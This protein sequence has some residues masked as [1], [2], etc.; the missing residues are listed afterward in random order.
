[1]EMYLEQGMVIDSGRVTSRMLNALLH[2]EDKADQ[3]KLRTMTDRVE[4]QGINY[5]TNQEEWADEVLRAHGFDPTTALPLANTV[6]DTAVLSPSG[7]FVDRWG[8]QVAEAEYREHVTEVISYFN[9]NRDV[10]EQIPE[11]LSKVRMM[12]TDPKSVVKVSLDGVFVKR[13]KDT[14]SPQDQITPESAYITDQ[15]DG[16]IDYSR[17][18][19]SKGRPKVETAVGH[20]EVDEKKYVLIGKNMFAVTKMVL[21]FLLEHDLLKNRTLVFFTDGGKDIKKCVDDLFAFCPHYVVLDWFHL[22]KHSLETLSMGLKG[23]KTNR[24]MQYEV[25]RRLFRILWVGNVEGAINYLEH[26]NPDW[27]KNKELVEYLKKKEPS[28]ACYALRRKMGLQI[29]SN[30]VEKANDLVVASRQKSKGMSW[31][32][33]GSWALACV[34][35]MYLNREEDNWHRKNVLKRELYPEYGKVFSVEAA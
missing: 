14:R 28:I 27:V 3:I 20:I 6:I 12:E 5:M 26:L 22:L 19:E 8:N 1:M 11:D 23:G 13:Q 31:S 9:E 29:S 16:P 33:E 32:R 25:R 10:T 15:N 35:A 2:R 21:A 18:P 4:Q 17:P 34:K 7:P 30:R 24:D